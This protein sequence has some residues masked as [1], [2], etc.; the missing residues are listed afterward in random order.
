MALGRA[1]SN[2][3]QKDTDWQ[4][5]Q[6]AEADH[7]LDSYLAALTPEEDVESTGSGRRFGNS[8]VYQL[9]L[10][11]LANERL[12]ELAAKQGT[13]PAAL[14]RDW[15]LQHLAEPDGSLQEP[16]NE[17]APPRSAHSGQP[18]TTATVRTTDAPGGMPEEHAWPEQDFGVETR[19]AQPPVNPDG[20]H[21][22]T[23]SGN[24]LPDPEQTEEITIPHGQLG[25]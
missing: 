19:P 13:S 10:P 21:T 6:V 14:A 25:R 12:K 15:V 11:L 5:E 20:A 4:D 18:T 2:R 3:R 9:R 24:R 7:E 16:T 17:A 8:Q 22:R 1:K 23:W